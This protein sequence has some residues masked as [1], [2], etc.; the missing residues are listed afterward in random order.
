MNT[1]NTGGYESRGQMHL[2]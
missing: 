2:P 1:K